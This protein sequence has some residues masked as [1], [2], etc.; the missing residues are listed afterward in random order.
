MRSTTLILQLLALF[1][2]LAGSLVADLVNVQVH[3]PD[4]I[5]VSGALG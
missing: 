3:L 4:R 5:I 1:G 2:L